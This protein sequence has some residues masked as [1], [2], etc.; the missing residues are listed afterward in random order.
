MSEIDHLVL[1]ILPSWEN[2]TINST[3][4]EGETRE[5]GGFAIWVSSL[6]GS[7]WIGGTEEEMKLIL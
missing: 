7:G 5:M 3:P 2:K 1:K 6:T 4:Y